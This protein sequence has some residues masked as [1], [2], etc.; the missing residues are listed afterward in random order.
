[1]KTKRDQK[2]LGCIFSR[3]F[4]F[5]FELFLAKHDSPDAA[6]IL[7]ADFFYTY[8]TLSGMQT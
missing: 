1:M 8:Y 4:Y 3:E 5:L 2:S 6:N 7:K